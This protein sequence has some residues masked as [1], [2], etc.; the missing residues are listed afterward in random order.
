[1]SHLNSPSLWSLPVPNADGHKYAR[2]CAVVFGG[3]K[4]TGA[5]R[6]ASSATMRIGAGLCFVV[7]SERSADI[8][9]ATLPAHV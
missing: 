1:M 5:A 7:S 2:G 9:R 4:M 6:L 8:Y 3:E